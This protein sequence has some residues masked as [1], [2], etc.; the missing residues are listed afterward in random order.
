MQKKKDNL[1]LYFV[2]LVPDEP[3]RSKLTEL[4]E[5]MYKEYGTKAALRS[6]PHITLH[7]PFKW[8]PEKENLLEESLSALANELTSFEVKLLN[9]SCFKPRVIYVGVEENSELDKVK[10]KVMDVSRKVWKLDLPRDMRG[11]HP[12]ITIGFRDLKKPEFFKA[13]D[14]V[15]DKPFESIFSVHT[16]TLLKHNGKSWDEFKQFDFLGHS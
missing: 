16:I 11:F 12:H 9:F 2:A 5:W 1:Q 4:K 8:K 10:K 7:M 14:A 6:P 3:L 15:K 13:W